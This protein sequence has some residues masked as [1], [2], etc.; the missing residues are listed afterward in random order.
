MNSNIINIDIVEGTTHYISIKCMHEISGAKFDLN[1]YRAV[2]KYT[3]GNETVSK[4][5][6][7]QGN[8]IIIKMEPSDTIG[9]KNL[10][11]ECRIISD[12]NHDVFPVCMGVIYIKMAN[13]V[14]LE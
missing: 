13:I 8:M 14:F 3:D 10:K 2:F 4:A 11:Y 9:K 6:D 5:A 1:K 7:V 12:V